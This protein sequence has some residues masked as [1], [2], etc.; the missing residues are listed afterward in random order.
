V[1]R[2]AQAQRRRQRRALL[3]ELGARVWGGQA[4]E[5]FGPAD[6]RVEAIIRRGRSS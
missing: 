2:E 3:V 6:R 4:T 5:S 1:T